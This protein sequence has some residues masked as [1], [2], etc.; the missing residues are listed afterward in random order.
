MDFKIINNYKELDSLE[1][2][3]DELVSNIDNPQVFY[4]FLWIKA[5]LENID[6]KQKNDLKIILVYNKKK[7]V[8]IFPFILEN[9]TLRFVTNKTVDYNNIYIKRDENKYAV[10]EKT[11][12]FIFEN[13]DFDGIELNNIQGDSELYILADILRNKLNK[14]VI[15]ED[16]VIAPVLI[17]DENSI[18]KFRNKQLK[19]IDR[20]KRKLL[21]DKDIKFEINC[22]VDDEFFEFVSN[23]HK[24]KWNHSVFFNKDYVNFYKEIVTLMKENIEAS[25]VIVDGEIVAAHFGFKD[26]KKVYYYIPT[27]K[28]EFSKNAVG[29]ILLKEL[30]DTYK[31]KEEFDFLRGNE[32]YKFNWTDNV[33]M[34]FNLYSYKSN[35]QNFI[36]HQKIYLKKSKLLRRILNK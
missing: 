1:Y 30:I 15:I 8:A 6:Y 10:I 22:K 16:S 17:N 20:R 7:L 5:Y 26:D 12:V 34:N 19:D 18:N 33:R 35:F 9:K 29:Y 3:W 13:I 23:N 2:E 21:K 4:K 32:L 36:N 24:K 27:Y 11:M 25:K 14:K 31:D 28:E